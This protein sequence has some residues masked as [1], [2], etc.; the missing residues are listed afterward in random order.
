MQGKSINGFTLQRL[1]GKGGMAEVW[2]AENKI[3]KP[4][5]VKILNDDLQLARP[6][7]C[8]VGAGAASRGT[9]ECR[10]GTVTTPA[11][12]TTGTGSASS[13]PSKT[14]WI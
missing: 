11:T 13:F 14:H 9:A 10:T 6:A 7:R 1:L 5:A 4:A 8:A 3:H 2:Y 12:G